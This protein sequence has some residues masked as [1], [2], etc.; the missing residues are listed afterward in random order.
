MT[1]S[2]IE[3]FRT[4]FWGDVVTAEDTGYDLA[5][6]VHNGLIDRRPAAVLRP[7]GVA[8]VIEAVGYATAQGLPV[9]IRGGAHSV[10]GH[11]T[12]DDGLVIDLSLL[13]GVQIDPVARRARV[14]GGALLGD[15]DRDGQLHGLAVPSGQV[16]NTG[17]AGLTLNGGMGCMQRKYGLTCDNLVSAQVVAADGRLVTASENENPDLFWAL[18]GGGGNFGVVTSFEFD[19]HPVGPLIYAGLIAYPMDQAVEVLSFLQDFIADAP[20]ELSADAIFQF[21]PP[22]EVIPDELKGKPL[23]GIFVRYIGSPEDGEQ[24]VK[25]L[26]EFGKPI[27]N[28]VGP[29]PYVMVQSM[30]DALN[31]KGWL[32]YWTGEYVPTLGTTELAT[33]AEHGSTL[34]SHASIIQVIP[35]NAAVTRVAPD[36]TAFAHRQDSWLVHYLAQWDDPAQT[37]ECRAWAKKSGADLHPLGSGDVYL[38]L[39]TDDEDTDRVRAFWDDDRL[40]RLAKVKSEYDPENMFRFNHNIKPA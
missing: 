40:G 2:P 35:F 39:V 31:P 10:A 18:R 34:P 36:A 6:R 25:P 4:T 23:I 24:A 26:L 32:N 3:Q 28:F 12:C 11:G 15:L 21:A 13:R 37:D 22:L 5:R 17:V 33:I 1:D 9:A 14:Q 27:F 7:R 19:L 16:S 38:N 8:S 20:E 30:L 29:A